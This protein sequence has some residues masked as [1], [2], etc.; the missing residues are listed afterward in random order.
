M[1]S[2]LL[3][4]L[5]G[6]GIGENNP[7]INPFFRYPFKSF[8]DIFGETP[9]LN[10]QYLHSSGNDKFIFPSDARLG[11][12]GLPQ[13]GTGQTSIFCGVNAPKLIG[14]HFGPYPYSTLIPVIKEKNIFREFIDREEKVAFA[15]AYPQ[16]FFDYVNSGKQR[17]SVTT[18]SCRLSGL[19]LNNYEDLKNGN[20]LSPEIDNSRWV[21]KLGYDLPI[22][23]PELAAERLL[24]IASLNKLTVFE[25]FL[26]DHLGHH[27]NFDTL[28]KTLE[29]LDRFL[30]HI[31][32]TL[33]TDISLLV[34]SDHGN[35]EDISVK[36]HT[37]NPALT[38]SAG[39]YAAEFA[40][41]ITDIS[42]I[43]PLIMELT[44]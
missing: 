32:T 24:K 30:F 22:I 16:I 34:C 35:L 8:T 29:C 14:Q 13:S 12:E 23:S 11:I 15:N 41:R 31:L 18:L 26:S 1:H 36:M 28:Q 6:I 10:A 43:K 3:I 4:F 2:I 27:R 19:R 44:K 42:Q 21:N 7:E 9:S 37:L 17:L 20:A 33:D 39:K 40:E 5:D 38:V 25:Y